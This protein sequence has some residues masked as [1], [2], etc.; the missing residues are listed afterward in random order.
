MILWYQFLGDGRVR[1]PLTDLVGVPDPWAVWKGMGL[2]RQRGV[3]RALVTVTVKPG[4]R[5]RMPDGSYTDLDSIE[6]DWKRGKAAA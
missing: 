1:D 5:G 2:E 3:L 6:F 4:R